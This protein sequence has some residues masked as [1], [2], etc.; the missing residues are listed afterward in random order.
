M[1][2]KIETK[3][4]NPFCKNSITFL[5]PVHSSTEL[6]F[7]LKGD[8]KVDR[9]LPF[10]KRW[11]QFHYKRIRWIAPEQ[12]VYFINFN[13][14]S[15]Y[16]LFFLNF[17][18]TIHVFKMLTFLSFTLKDIILWKQAQACLNYSL[19]ILGVLTARR[20]L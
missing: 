13:R 1:M 15:K 8:T 20:F 10:P 11:S 6:R 5:N 17:W 3:I 14:K 12:L 7:K 16:F 9:I 19:I 2:I 4:L 18:N